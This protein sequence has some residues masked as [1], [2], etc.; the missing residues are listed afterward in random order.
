MLN[1]IAR[2]TDGWGASF[3]QLGLSADKT[4]TEGVGVI[5]PHFVKAAN[6]T[7]ALTAATVTSLTEAH[8]RT[9]L[10]MD[11]ARARQELAQANECR[12]MLQEKL[13]SC[14]MDKEEAI[15]QQLQLKRELT[16]LSREM[17]LDR[18]VESDRDRRKSDDDVWGQSEELVA[19]LRGEV[20]RLSEQLRLVSAERDRADAMR[21][22]SQSGPRA[23][24]E[25]Q[26]SVAAPETNG[27]SLTPRSLLL[28]CQPADPASPRSPAVPGTDGAVSMEPSDLQAKIAAAA[29]D[30]KGFAAQL[31]AAQLDAEKA[32]KGEQKLRELYEANLNDKKQLARDF[33]EVSKR[34]R[35]DELRLGV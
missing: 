26:Q 12:D 21:A 5:V 24:D 20:G 13:T 31:Q 6:T 22:A 10:E 33:T 17:K 1:S 27:R 3:Q 32:N 19:S 25:P 18:M 29:R 8:E 15:H 35:P 2:A 7:V 4:I 30:S 28:R 16:R 34:V 14:L 11:L 9:E 23:A